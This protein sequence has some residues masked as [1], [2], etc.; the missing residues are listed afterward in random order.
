MAIASVKVMVND[1]LPYTAPLAF[2]V[3]IERTRVQMCY[4]M[5]SQTAKSDADVELESNYRAL[6]NMLF[7]AMVAYQL[8]KSKVVQNMAGDGTNAGTAAKTLKRGKADVTEAEFIV[9]KASDGALIQMETSVFLKDLL[10][11]ICTMG[12]SMGYS[13]PWCSLPMDQIPAFIVGEDFPNCS[14]NYM[15]VL[16]NG[17]IG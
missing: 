9:V 8:V 3:I 17:P 7:A 6:E 2:D 14:P 11:E 1:R 10:M 16:F 15:D 12:R 13:V 4:L 5:Q